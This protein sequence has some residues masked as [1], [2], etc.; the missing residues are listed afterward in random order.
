MSRSR[1]PFDQTTAIVGLA[2]WCLCDAYLLFGAKVLQSSKHVFFFFIFSIGD[3]AELVLNTDTALSRRNWFP[4]I[5]VFL[6]FFLNVMFTQYNEPC[7]SFRKVTDERERW[8][9]KAALATWGQVTAARGDGDLLFLSVE[10]LQSTP[11]TIQTQVVGFK[12]SL[13]QTAWS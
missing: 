12:R 4:D 10:Q 2:L 1:G 11:T 8:V 5:T 7:S 6:L 13:S 3:T 9:I